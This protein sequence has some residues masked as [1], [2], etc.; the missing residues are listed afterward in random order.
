MIRR[1]TDDDDGDNEGDNEDDHGDGDDDD[2]MNI[3]QHLLLATWPVK[4]WV[5]QESRRMF[6]KC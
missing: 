2:C 1:P 6:Q 4:D 5:S 3:E